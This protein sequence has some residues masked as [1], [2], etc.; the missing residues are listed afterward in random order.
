MECSWGRDLS[1]SSSSS[2][3]CAGLD[4]GQC[5]AGEGM[6]PDNSVMGLVLR[7]LPPSKSSAWMA[8]GLLR[9]LRAFRREIVTPALRKPTGAHTAGDIITLDDS[10]MAPPPIAPPPSK[11]TV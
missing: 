4:N 9:I 7:N 3:F 10:V 11:F 5:I 6:T 2:S 8:S 1:G